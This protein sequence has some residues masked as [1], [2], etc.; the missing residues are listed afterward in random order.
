MRYHLKGYILLLLLYTAFDISTRSHSEGS[1]HHSIRVTGVVVVLV[2][3]VVHIPEVRRAV[4]TPKPPVV[5]RTV[6]EHNLY[7][8]IY[9]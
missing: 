6:I 3:V 8:I 5:R 4:R 2:A 9:N 1:R 7:F